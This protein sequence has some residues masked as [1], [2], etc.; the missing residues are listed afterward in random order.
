MALSPQ[1]ARIG[2]DL[3]AKLSKQLADVM[4]TA[5]DAAEA[6]CPIKTG[7]LVS[8]F[9][10]TVRAPFTGVAGSPDAVD[11]SAQDAGREAVLTYDVGR[12]GKIYLRNN[13]EYLKYLPPFLTEALM[14]GVAAMPHG[15]KTATRKMLKQM[16]RDVFKKGG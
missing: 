16:A 3:R 6:H 8:N 1:A 2:R 12:D 5:A 9:I 7:H 10:L 11:Y 4:L 15:R 13:V 14:A